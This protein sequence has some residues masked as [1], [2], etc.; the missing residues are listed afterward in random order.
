MD[1]PPDFIPI[2]GLVIVEVDDV[3]DGG[4]EQHEQLMIRLT[5]QFWQT[6]LPEEARG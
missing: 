6:G 4:D 1:G 5:E 2:K 3:L